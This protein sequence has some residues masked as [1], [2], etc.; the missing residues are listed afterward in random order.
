MVLR[1]NESGTYRHCSNYLEM[2]GRLI[3]ESSDGDSWFLARHPFSNTLM[4]KHQPDPSSGGL[5]SYI[6]IGRFLRQGAHGPEQQ[7]LLKLINSLIRN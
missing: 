5:V 3:Y 6:E 4:V 1:S 2:S 7:D